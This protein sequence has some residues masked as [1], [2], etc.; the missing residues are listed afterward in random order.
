MQWCLVMVLAASRTL[1]SA[2]FQNLLRG[3]QGRGWRTGSSSLLMKRTS[4]STLSRSQARGRS[5]ACVARAEAGGRH[6]SFASLF[7]RRAD[8]VT[9][10]RRVTSVM[11]HNLLF[12]PHAYSTA[13]NSQ[14]EHSRATVFLYR[15]SSLA[16]LLDMRRRFKAVMDVLGAM[17]RSGVSLSRSVEVTV[18]WDR[19][20]A[21]GPMHPVTLDDLS[22]DPALEIGAFF[23]AA[24]DIHRR[25]STFIHQV[26]VHR[27][28]EAIRG[29]RNWIREDPM[30]H[31][32]R[33]LRP[34][35]VPLAP[36]LQCEPHLTPGGS[37]VLADPARID[38]EFRKAFFVVLG[39]G[40]PALRNSILRWL[41][42]LLEVSLPRL[43]GQV[44]ADVVQRESAAAGSLGGWGWRKLKVL[45]VSW[46]DELASILTLVE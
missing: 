45:L 1:V 37:G 30:V 41:P 26:V 15:D 2:M 38:E 21:L 25:L 17:I 20:L 7:D 11:H 40:I 19:I 31:P 32:F 8:P 34:D 16:P 29:W 5:S 43:T 24:S 10:F 12:T 13:R 6:D 36:F 33:W 44:L 9:R 46:Y 22:L 42:L 14:L 35:L 23:R 4:S 3:R 39:K 28:D 18:Q 27:R